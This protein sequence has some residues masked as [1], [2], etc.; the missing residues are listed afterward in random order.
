MQQA[1]PSGDVIGKSFLRQLSKEVDIESSSSFKNAIKEDLSKQRNALNENLKNIGNEKNKEYERQVKEGF[2][3]APVTEQ[4]N[5]RFV[6]IFLTT[7]ESEPDTATGTTNDEGKQPVY[8]PPWTSHT[9]MAREA[10][11][12]APDF[13]QLRREPKDTFQ[14][15]QDDPTYYDFVDYPPGR[16][17]PQSHGKSKPCKIL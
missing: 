1:K 16:R 5:K 7:E 12:R 10:A 13:S 14:N 3:N 8:D 15:W 4:E 17:P 6:D 9:E 11:T 2:E